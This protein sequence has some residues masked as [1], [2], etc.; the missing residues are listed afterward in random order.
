MKYVH[1]HSSDLV[2]DVFCRHISIAS[3]PLSG[4]SMHCLHTVMA[5]FMP[6]AKGRVPLL[7]K[8]AS[9]HRSSMHVATTQTFGTGGVQR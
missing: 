6:Q 9:L 8:E 5:P 2:I 3:I 7:Y 1:V 4:P